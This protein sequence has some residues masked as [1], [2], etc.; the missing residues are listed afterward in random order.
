MTKTVK[1]PS[2]FIGLTEI[3]SY[4]SGLRDGF[5][6]LGV[7]CVFVPLGRNRYG[8]GNSAA[9]RYI[10]PKIVDAVVRSGDAMG[11]HRAG[12]LLHRFLL[13]L[14]AKILLLI[15]AMIRFDVFIFGFASTFFRYRELPILRA[16]GKKIIFAFNGSDSRPPFLDG[17]FSHETPDQLLQHAR[18]KKGNLRVIER[19]AHYCVSLPTH[20]HY[21]EKRFINHLYIGLPCNIPV[22]EAAAAPFVERPAARIVHAPSNPGP[23]GSAVFREVIRRLRADGFN[24]EYIELTGKPNSVVLDCLS[25]CDIVLDQAYSDVS[26]AG[27][28]LEA[29]T[30]GKPSVVGGYARSFIQPAA[31]KAGV[32]V[33]LFVRPEEL[34]G[35]IREL[36]V[37]PELRRRTGE[38]ARQFVLNNWNAKRVAE[39]FLRIAHDDVP[40]EWWFDPADITYLHGGG[41]HETDVRRTLKDVLDA[42]GVEGLQ[43]TDKPELQE[44][45]CRFGGFGAVTE[46][47]TIDGGSR[48]PAHE[49][50]RRQHSPVAASRR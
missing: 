23:K 14:P 31:D 30:F 28:S 13:M 25:S 38:R 32:P 46:A 11:A 6:E 36:L 40:E 15:W 1:H 39:R 17:S 50:L 43:L 42:G 12:R 18:R 20:A 19:Y 8:R 29:A 5:V 26:F 24:I 48:A 4:Y 44:H 41:M 45:L 27:F 9:T 10:V 3:A 7:D 49:R 37:D 2:V 33:E 47:S 16:A 34:E 21:H 22:R 35:L